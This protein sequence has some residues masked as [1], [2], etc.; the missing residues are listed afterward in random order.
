MGKRKRSERQRQVRN[1]RRHAKPQPKSPSPQ[2]KPSR[3][4]V[5]VIYAGKD[6][7]LLAKNPQRQIKPKVTVVHVDSRFP[8]PAKYPQPRDKVFSHWNSSPYRAGLSAEDVARIAR[9]ERERITGFLEIP[10]QCATPRGRVPEDRILKKR[11]DRVKKRL[12]GDNIDG[13]EECS[14]DDCMN[15]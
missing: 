10:A 13:D 5:T 4:M 2:P 12:F 3:P 14:C 15:I 1:R 9:W 6:P 7:V 11:M 8:V